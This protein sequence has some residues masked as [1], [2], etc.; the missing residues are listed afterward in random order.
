[1]GKEFEHYLLNTS[2]ELIG[3]SKYGKQ[4]VVSLLGKWTM[5]NLAMVN[6]R[7]Q[8]ISSSGCWIIRFNELANE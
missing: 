6:A 7:K 5:T 8:R 1:M 3:I 2:N 4:F